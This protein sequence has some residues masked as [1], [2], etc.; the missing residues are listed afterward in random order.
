MNDPYIVI[1]PAQAARIA[2][3]T[4][5]TGAAISVSQ[6]GNTLTLNTGCDKFSINSGGGDIVPNNQEPLC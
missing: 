6:Y 1:L 3:E 5:K 4:A 2:Q